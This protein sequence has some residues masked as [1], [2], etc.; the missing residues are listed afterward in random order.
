MM[1]DEYKKGYSSFIIPHSSF[2]VDPAAL[3]VLLATAARARIVSPNLGR[4]ADD[5]FDLGAFALHFAGSL[6]ILVGDADVCSLSIGSATQAIPLRCLRTARHYFGLSESSSR[7][8]LFDAIFTLPWR[9]LSGRRHASPA[10]STHV[11]KRQFSGILRQ[12]GES[13]Q[14]V[15]LRNRL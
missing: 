13:D 15:G 5:L 1:N 3:L 8:G 6:C 4:V 2:G 14:C 12:K 11:S 7:I 10:F 9:G